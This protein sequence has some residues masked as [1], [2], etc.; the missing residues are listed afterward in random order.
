MRQ[1]SLRLLAYFEV[2][3][4]RLKDTH[5]RFS[6]LKANSRLA[7]AIVTTGMQNA[8]LMELLATG[9]FRL[10][11]LDDGQIALKRPSLR[12]FV[13]H[14]EDYPPDCAVP[15]QGIATV[16]TTALLATHIR[17]GDGLVTRTLGVLY[18]RRSLAAVRGG[19]GEVEAASWTTLPWHPAARRFFADRFPNP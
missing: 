3:V 12:P 14:Q 9:Q 2:P 11:D 8:E 15:P 1:T 6:E 5:R 17:A 19:I 16:A 13:L 7:A 10:R 4:D 18:D